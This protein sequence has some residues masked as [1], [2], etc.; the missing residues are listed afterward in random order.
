MFWIFGWGGS[1][2]VLGDGYTLQCPNCH[3]TRTWQVVRSSLRASVFFIP[4]A[5]WNHKYQM[6]CPV[7]SAGMELE[8]LQEAQEALTTTH[9]QTEALRSRFTRRL[10]EGVRRQG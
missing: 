2:K 9:Q 3:N 7:C 8:S 10:G 5:Q 6:V 1:T 4:V